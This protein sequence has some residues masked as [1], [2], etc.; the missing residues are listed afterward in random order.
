MRKGRLRRLG[1]AGLLAMGLLAGW[2]ITV[3]AAGA[4]EVSERPATARARPR[5]AGAPDLPPLGR[6]VAEVTP[7]VG[8]PTTGD[9]PPMPADE[10]P[11]L[12]KE[13]KAPSADVPTKGSTKGSATESAKGSPTASVEDRATVQA[14]HDLNRTQIQMGSLAKTRGFNK[15]TRSFGGQLMADHKLAERKLDAYLRKHGTSVDALVTASLSPD[16]VLLATRTGADFDREFTLQII[17]DHNKVID[18]I[19]TAASATSDAELRAIYEQVLPILRAHKRA[20]QDIVSGAA[21]S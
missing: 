12:P 3:S 11:V 5:D 20:A 15:A 14:L 4:G 18:T 9:P 8:Q 10:P 2:Q 1:R 7:P 17:A 16:H 19:E 6:A 21:H 13:A